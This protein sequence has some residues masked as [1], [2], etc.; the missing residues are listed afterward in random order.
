[1]ARGV[2]LLKDSNASLQTA[3]SALE[4]HDVSS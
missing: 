1:L 2:E 3:L 4:V